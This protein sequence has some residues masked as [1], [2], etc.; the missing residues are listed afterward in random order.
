MSWFT[1]ARFGMFIHWGPYSVAGRAE[2]IANREMIP[3]HEY[4]EKHAV[5]FK[6]ER[7]DPHAWIRLAKEAGMKY[8]VLTTRHHDGFALWDSKV[9]NFN[10]AR[11]GPKKDLLGPFA[12][13]VRSEGLKLGFYYSG[14]NW[15]HSDYPTPYARSWPQEWH[16][17]DA[18]KRFIA[19]YYAEL[20]ELMTQYGPVDIL[21]Y[22][23]C[24]PWPFEGKTINEKIKQWQPGIL[25]S[26]RNS[27]PGDP[28]DFA[29]CE[30]SLKG[31]E[32]VWESCITLN[33][34]WGYHAGDNRWK[35]PQTVIQALVETAGKGGNLL[36]NIGPKAD[37]TVPGESVRIVREVGKWLETNREFLPNSSRSPFGP[38]TTAKFTTR[39][40]VAYIHLFYDPLGEL[41]WA[42]LANEIKD[43]R[44]LATGETVQWR[45]EN[46]RIFFAL[47]T[48]LPDP[49]DTVIRV[50]TEGEPRTANA[51]VSTWIPE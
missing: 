9:N 28:Y 39:D 24:L 4:Y 3:F 12:N 34:H 43:V 6:A 8:L 5:R 2:W 17:E 47:P 29:I 21:W 44:L 32:G 41:C 45:R 25:I 15:Y 48:P 16:S 50:E 20:E 30:Q 40:N 51:I 36:L 38:H 35:D 10:A 49:L 27:E 18:R 33:D 14:A 13:A 37:G 46:N 23:G 31:K 11:M 7:Y 22:D 42:D 19:Y 1:E 26:E